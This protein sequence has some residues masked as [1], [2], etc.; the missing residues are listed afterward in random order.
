LQ[1]VD[2]AGY[3]RPDLETFSE[4]PTFDAFRHNHG[5]EYQGNPR[6]LVDARLV[7]VLW[8]VISKE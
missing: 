5:M 1:A 6:G 8:G 4:P 7:N 2:A 3:W